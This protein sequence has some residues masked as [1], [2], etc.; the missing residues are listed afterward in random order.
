MEAYTDRNGREIQVGDVLIYDEGPGYGQSIEEVIEHECELATLMR[1]GE[2]KWT[3]LDTQEP[4]P[5][6]YYK[7][8]PGSSE[9]VAIHAAVTDVD[10]D[11]AFTPEYAESVFGT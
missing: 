6:V 8:Y 3:V 9:N 1:V 2:P 4:M 7:I 5:L 10:H 11:T